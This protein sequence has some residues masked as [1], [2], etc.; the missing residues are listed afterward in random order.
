MI[1]SKEMMFLF[2]F[3]P[4]KNDDLTFKAFE[5]VILGT[6]LCRVQEKKLKNVAT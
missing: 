4:Q 1:Q 2:F 3:D 5:S 6:I